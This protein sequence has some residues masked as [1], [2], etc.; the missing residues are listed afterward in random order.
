[1]WWEAYVKFKV[2]RSR[3]KLQLCTSVFRTPFM[4]SRKFSLFVDEKM[5]MFALNI[6]IK[7]NI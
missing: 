7:S 4:N 3:F 6:G 5:I 1:M 2:D